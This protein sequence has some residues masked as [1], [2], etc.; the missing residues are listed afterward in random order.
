MLCCTS[1]ADTLLLRPPYNVRLGL[2]FGVFFSTT[3]S[4]FG[5]V[6]LFL[7]F[8]VCL[9]ERLF[10]GF[11]LLPVCFSVV[12]VP[13]VL[14]FDVVLLLTAGGFADFLRPPLRRRRRVGFFSSE[15][16]LTD[17]VIVVTRSAVIVDICPRTVT[18]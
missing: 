15:S 7:A 5:G 12:S 10:V 1:S 2:G 8:L 3:F 6:D 9:R 13:E 11:F 14:S 16:P 17:S 4:T 18:P